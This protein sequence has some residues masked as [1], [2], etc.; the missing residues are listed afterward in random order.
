MG[1]SSRQRK[2]GRLLVVNGS[3]FLCCFFVGRQS[4]SLQQ[5]MGTGISE[6]TAHYV[7]E[8]R[9]NDEGYMRRNQNTSRSDCFGHHN[10]HHSVT[11]SKVASLQEKM[12]AYYVKRQHATRR[13]NNAEARRLL[14]NLVEVEI[15]PTLKKVPAVK[16][17]PRSDRKL[18]KGQEKEDYFIYEHFY[19]EKT[20]QCYS[21]GSNLFE[22][23]ALDGF[24]YSNT[25]F[26]EQ[27]FNASSI[28]VEAADSNWQQ[29]IIKVPKLRPLAISHRAAL[30]PLGA[31]SVCMQIGDQNATSSVNRN[32]KTC[33]DPVPC[34]HFD[35]SLHYSLISLDIEGFEL[36]FLRMRKPKADIIIIEV[37]QWARDM[38]DLMTAVELV[39]Y[40]AD[41]GYYL[42][43]QTVGLRNFLFLSQELVNDCFK[44]GGS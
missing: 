10:F 32:A 28:L 19:N 23:G 44:A 37:V 26:F 12:K 20:K 41:I 7:A 24:R 4:V 34:F 22:S 14:N 25:Y 16:G 33:E 17:L 30:C 31:E 8:H 18:F 13:T 6:S 15:V 21:F 5:D 39:V 11:A 2:Q 43:E 38:E 9:A 1:G 27:H 40:L 36:D 35:E 3:V 42:Y 29:L